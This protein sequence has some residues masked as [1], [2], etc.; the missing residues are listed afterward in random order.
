[1]T[2]GQLLEFVALVVAAGA[3]WTFIFVQLPLLARTR[4]RHDVARLRDRCVD[5]VIEGLLRDG[6]CADDFVARCEA[7]VRSAKYV[8][9]HHAL[10]AHR[11]LTRAGWDPSHAPE[12]P[13]VAD[14][15]PEGRKL[16]HLLESDLVQVGRRY[17]LTGSPLGW[18]VRPG[19]WL[20]RT[21]RKTPPINPSAEQLID[22]TSEVAVTLPP[23][24][25]GPSRGLAERLTE[26]SMRHAAA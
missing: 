7:L 16:M 1:M 2:R 12:R 11:I 25:L 14:L 6:P 8:T 26:A 18:I 9:L 3:L 20:R 22:E 23:D 15:S 19:L 17:L 24:T 21:V 5:A 10:L 4:F 13:S